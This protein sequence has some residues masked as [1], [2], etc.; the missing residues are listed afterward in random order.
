MGEESLR[1]R[2]G[3]DSGE[4]DGQSI[5]SDE[6]RKTNLQKQAKL[7]PSPS[8]CV[9]AGEGLAERGICAHIPQQPQLRPGLAPCTNILTVW[10]V[11]I[12]ENC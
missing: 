12:L 6:P 4:E 9:R 11:Y 1:K 5:Q 3:E 10:L 8:V 7:F 2:K